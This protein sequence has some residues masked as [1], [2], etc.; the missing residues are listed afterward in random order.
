MCGLNLAPGLRLASSFMTT[1]FISHN[2]ESKIILYE[3]AWKGLKFHQT[4]FPTAGSV[5]SHEDHHILILGI[6][7]K[8]S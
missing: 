1:G 8:A 6:H 5:P 2:T 7:Y 4:V 3:N